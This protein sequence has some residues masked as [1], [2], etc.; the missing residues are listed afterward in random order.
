MNVSRYNEGV[1]GG[2][3]PKTN[4][5]KIR[6]MSDA[7]LAKFLRETVEVS[8]HNLFDCDGRECTECEKCYLEWLQ[9]EA[10]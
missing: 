7:E 4:A 3:L 1:F 9:S 2:K 5:D 6:A 10:E 8:A